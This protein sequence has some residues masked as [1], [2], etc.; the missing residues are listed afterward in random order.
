MLKKVLFLSLFLLISVFAIA[1]VTGTVAEIDKYG[2]VHTDIL[3]EKMEAAGLEVG[4]MLQVTHGEEI[5]EVPFVTTYGDVDRGSVLV[6]I[7]G[8][9]VLI[10]VNYGNCSKTYGLNL[11][12]TVEI[13]LVA[14][15]TYKEELEIRH[16][17][18]TEE[19]SDYASNEIFSNFREINMG[20]IKSGLLYRTS[21]PSMDD[22]RSPY[23]AKF[24]EAAGIET[25][26]NLSDSDE[27][28]AENYTFNEY[29]K[30]LGEQGKVIN[31]NMGVDLLSDEFAQKLQEGLLFIIDNEPPY[32][33]HCVEGKDRAGMV[34]AILGAIMNATTEEIY[35]DYVISYENYYNVEPGTPAYTAVE[36]IIVG[37]LKSM[38]YENA[39]DNGNVKDVVV[40][41]LKERVGPV[42]YTHLRAHET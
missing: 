32:L 10:A 6:R 27:E 21:H 20:D 12:D 2:N 19:R 7:S 1:Q 42:S 31:L 22:P 13:S 24:V 37:I 23:A 33:V 14:K 39:V 34:S 16:L 8:G 41:Y 15:G 3:Q 17:V 29:Y 30:S 26:I 35:K 18:R 38:N 25:V 11:E 36:N 40:E 5:I 28:L 4:D 9:H